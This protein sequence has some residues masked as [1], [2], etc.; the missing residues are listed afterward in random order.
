MFLGE[1][2]VAQGL[3]TPDEIRIA[4]LRQ[5]RKGGRIGDNLVEL[6][7]ITRET[8]NVALREQYTRAMEVIAREDLLAHTE[9]RF[10]SEHPQ[11]NHQRCRLAA[12]L[13]VGGQTA[14]ARKHAERGFTG[15]KAT[16]GDE[17]AW[18]AEC[19]VTLAAAN[20]APLPG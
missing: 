17:H 1:L 5:Q 2:L 4:L 16:L 12:A 6:G 8:L 20:D 11:T 3:A 19:A 15:L 13:V 9:R 7:I 14:D 18:T 10:G